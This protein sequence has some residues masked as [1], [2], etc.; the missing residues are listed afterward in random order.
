MGFV[1]EEGK[2]KRGQE[3]EKWRVE[4]GSGARQCQ[5]TPKSRERIGSTLGQCQ[6]REE[7][8]RR[9]KGVGLRPEM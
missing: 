8:G 7:S 1:D 6:V 9:E 4:N 5:S 3:K 2:R